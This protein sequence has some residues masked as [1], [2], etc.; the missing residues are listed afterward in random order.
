MYIHIVSYFIY[1]VVSYSICSFS[2][3][4]AFLY[5]YAHPSLHVCVCLCLLCL[6]LLCMRVCLCLYL[7]LISCWLAYL[8]AVCTHIHIYTSILSTCTY[9]NPSIRPPTHPSIHPPINPLIH[10]PSIHLSIH[11]PMSQSIRRWYVYL[12]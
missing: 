6:V 10:H 1:Y 11:P 4:H 12:L 9:T 2:C 8:L 3:A 7:H 5:F